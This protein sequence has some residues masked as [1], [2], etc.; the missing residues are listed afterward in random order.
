M[1]SEQGLVTPEAVRLDLPQATVGSRGIAILVDWFVQFMLLFAFLFGFGLFSRDLPGTAG[2]VGASILIVLTFLIW[3]GYPIG[4]ET[5]WR[6]RTLGKRLL[7][8]RVVTVEG[9]PITFRHAAIRGALG[10]VDFL[11]TFGVAAVVSSL[12][13]KRNQ[14]LGDFVAGTVVLRERTGAD[15][16]TAHTFTV[17]P[18]AAS[19]A[20]GL[21]PSGLT[22]RDY[23]AI[24][25]Y[26]MRAASLRPQRRQEVGRQILDAVAPRLGAV[27]PNDL[28]PD[29]LLTAIAARYQGQA[30]QQ[31]DSAS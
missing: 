10:L 13:S 23:A 30:H 29:V 16:A 26:L 21:D 24:R 5:V 1:T 4:L 2:W 22:D 17:P 12:V 20:D 31:T 27:P 11:L 18:I 28:P 19:M 9:G 8:L 25:S 14:R 6:G 15:A 3:F 7:G